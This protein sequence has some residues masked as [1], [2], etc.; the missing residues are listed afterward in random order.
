MVTIP[1]AEYGE[2]K[3]RQ[4]LLHMCVH[5]CQGKQLSLISR[6]E[7]HPLGTE[8]TPFGYRPII[9]PMGTHRVKKRVKVEITTVR[10][11][12]K[13]NDMHLVGNFFIRNS[14]ANFQ[15]SGYHH[16]K[17]SPSGYTQWPMGFTDHHI[18]RFR[19]LGDGPSCVRAPVGE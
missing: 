17:H 16:A 11:A 6:H 19:F 5:V 1:I 4:T 13:F 15:K 12:C 18:V 8:N 2:L 3:K 14:P 9:H 10:P 7:S